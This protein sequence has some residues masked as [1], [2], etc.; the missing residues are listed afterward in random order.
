M[1]KTLN[2][3]IE[4]LRGRFDNRAL[5]YQSVHKATIMLQLKDSETGEIHLHNIEYT[6]KDAEH[7][8]IAKE[9]L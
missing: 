4:E 3:W 9:E 5:T 6:S 7:L 1:K 8:T 2:E